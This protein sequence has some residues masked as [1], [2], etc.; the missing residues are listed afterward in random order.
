MLLNA[1]TLL[2]P[3]PDASWRVWKPRATAAGAVL[4][5]PSEVGVQ[6]KP[7]VI[8]LPATACRTVGLILPNAD[9][10]ILEQIIMTQLERR[11]MKLEGGTARNFR[12]HLLT[13][14]AASATVSVDVLAD[15]FPEDLALPQASDYT[16]A[17]RLATLPQG[18][19]VIT[20]EH[21]SL[22]L[23]MGFQGK[24]Y[25]SHLFA[26]A[27]VPAEDIALE[28]VLA[29][30]TLENELGAGSISGVALV[31]SSWDEA[32][33]SSVGSLTGLPVRVIDHLPPN[34]QLDTHNWTRLLPT[35][36][37]TAQDSSSRRGKLIRFGILGGLLLVA[38]A[39]FA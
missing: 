18:Q 34:S 11:G 23:A 7:L 37:R 2:L 16:A 1:A 6:V 10:E 4:E 3:A 22:V 13:Q 28:I 12:W 38:L 25:H 29:R 14:T 19:M 39:F 30:L 8:G 17:L 26:P 20:E 15:P 27:T 36:V 35:S 21:G 32:I 31:G 33:S 5:R 9:H 24:L